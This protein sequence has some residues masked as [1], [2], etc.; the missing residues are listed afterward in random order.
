MKKGQFNVTLEINNLVLDVT[1]KAESM[2]E[3]ITKAEVL[4]VTDVLVPVYEEDGFSDFEKPRI[5]GVWTA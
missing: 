4:K 2:A 5:T 1:I 3:A